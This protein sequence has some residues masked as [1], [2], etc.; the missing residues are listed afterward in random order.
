M[1]Y[2][3]HSM[4]SPSGAYAV[5][6]GTS[7]ALTA[8]T[9]DATVHPPLVRAQETVA[10]VVPRVADSFRTA[11]TSPLFISAL[12][13]TLIFVWM[14]S[15]MRRQL[16][17]LAMGAML[18]IALTSFTAPRKPQPKRVVD[19]KSTPRTTRNR[20]QSQSWNGYSYIAPRPVEQPVVLE[21][22][23]P[24]ASPVPDPRFDPVDIVLPATPV[25][26]MP[27]WRDDVMRNV[28]REAQRLMRDPQFREIILRLRAQAR[29]EARQRRWRRDF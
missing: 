11:F 20:M 22:P 8:R 24:S 19:L 5:R 3:H 7:A 4:S 17:G 16:A 1:P 14:L 13:L 9:I 15:R 6:P 25:T 18:V 2:P 23:D 26:P 28:E 12:A 27:E 21:Y 10:Q 29:E